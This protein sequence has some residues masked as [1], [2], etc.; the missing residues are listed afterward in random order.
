[1]W[2]ALFQRTRMFAPVPITRVVFHRS[3]G[4]FMLSIMLVPVDCRDAPVV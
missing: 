2:S 4:M 3:C 1:M